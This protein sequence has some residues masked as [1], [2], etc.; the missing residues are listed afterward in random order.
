MVSIN[1]VTQ[2][3]TCTG[4]KCLLLSTGGG[5]DLQL[6]WDNNPTLDALPVVQFKFGEDEICLPSTD[7]G[8]SP[9]R[10]DFILRKKIRSRCTDQS[11]R[12]PNLLDTQTEAT[13]F[14]NNGGLDTLIA[15][16]ID[17]KTSPD[18]G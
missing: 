4:T 7:E 8:L 12:W 13:V 15:T 6:N 16:T 2:G 5:Y 14:A 9:G 18:F 3:A 1:K 11:S 17:A 10:V